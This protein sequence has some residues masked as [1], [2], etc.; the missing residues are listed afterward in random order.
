MEVL[1][2]REKALGGSFEDG[3]VEV[4]LEEGG[5]KEWLARRRG[6][7]EAEI[8]SPNGDGGAGKLRARVRERERRRE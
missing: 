4:E 7:A 5:I 1:T 2:G 6:T 3:E 8:E